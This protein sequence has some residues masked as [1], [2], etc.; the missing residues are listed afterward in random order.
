[1][2]NMEGKKILF[3]GPK[4]FN[5]ETEIKNCLEENGAEVYY[6]NDKPFN[7]LFLI[8]ILRLFPKLIWFYCDILYK[9]KLLKISENNFDYVFV[10]KGEG[11]SN[12]MLQKLRDKFKDTRFILYLWDS[13]KNIK[14]IESKI[15]Y[16]DK[17]YSFDPIDCEQI[18]K[19]NY[20][21]L[22]FLDKYLKKEVY[23]DSNKIFFIGT[24]NGDRS[25]IVSNVIESINAKIIFDYWLYVRSTIEYYFIKYFKIENLEISRLIRKPLTASE[26]STKFENSTAIL[27][28][29]HHSQNGLTMRTFEVLA[30]GKKLITT[31]ENIRNET[32]F[33]S[34]LILIIDR[35]NPII[36]LSFLSN[37]SNEISNEFLT[38]YSL[39]G[40]ITQI[41]Q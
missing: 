23:N 31:N 9:K 34:N 6:F 8:A 3:F 17:I 28:I 15:K 5:Y 2:N 4:T 24:L 37:K 38:K 14:G 29:E 1:M 12:F 30:S 11:L 22:F 32:F 41:F 27:D 26:I 20:R 19:F 13:V 39:K 7:N 21:P 35:N 36:P 25:K 18:N 33:D 16:F 10:I 40:W